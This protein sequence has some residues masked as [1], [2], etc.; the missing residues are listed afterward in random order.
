MSLSLGDVVAYLKADV[1][2]FNRGLSRARSAMSGASK[3]ITEGFNTMSGSTSG[4][5]G[6]IFKA[7][8]AVEALKGAFTLLARVAKTVVGV[9]V[10]TAKK[11]GTAA[12][13]ILMLSSRANELKVALIAVG[14]NT[15]IS[16]ERF[17]DY[18]K[19]LRATGISIM[20]ARKVLLLFTQNQ[21]DLTKVTELATV[22]QNLAVTAGMDSSE[23]MEQ[24][25]EAI[26]MQRPMLLRQFGL[27]TT[28]NDIYEK[29][30][31][32][33]TK[34]VTK[35]G[36]EGI[37]RE[38]LVRD[39]ALQ[40]ERVV[41]LNDSEKSN[42]ITRT[43]AA[44]RLTDMTARLNETKTATV[45]LKD[46]MTEEQKAAAILA[47]IM[48]EG[49]KSVGVYSESMGT[50]SKVMR[51][52]TGRVLPDMAI[53]LGDVVRPE[54]DKFITAIYDGLKKISAKM[55]PTMARMRQLW[56]MLMVDIQNYWNEYGRATFDTIIEKLRDIF[57]R[58][59]D[60]VDSENAK[61]FFE[62]LG[63]DTAQKALDIMSGMVDK[64]GIFIDYL[65]SDDFKTD[66]ENFTVA[67]RDLATVVTTIASALAWA[68]SSLADLIGK[69]REWRK[70]RKESM[71]ELSEIG[72]S[73][74]W[75]G[76]LW[77]WLKKADIGLDWFG[78]P[79]MMADGVKNFAGGLAVVGERGR[80]LVQL[81]PGSNV[82]P[83]RELGGLGATINLTVNMAGAVIPSEEVAEDFAEAVGDSIFRKLKARNTNYQ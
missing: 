23:A 29:Y 3:R 72:K 65:G 16:E 38:K 78:S 69:Y 82:I 15:G 61:K 8:V 27:V 12:Y 66:L 63:S 79:G 73:E 21:L 22:A 31:E 2:D 44:N 1:S 62:Q 28:V 83:N 59:K 33:Q 40:E 20:N 48:D 68:V 45:T 25:T 34:T 26:I 50:A 7:Q 39:I 77:D 76:G 11:V 70:E 32:T 43:T 81:P 71:D 35:M 9:F 52:I 58:L 47:Y 64:L 10:N 57:D 67:M 42:N 46:A 18:E 30:G 55:E 49:S 53:M 56:E 5:T 24:M 17:A 60:L 41:S 6:K 13:N 14:K 19:Q 36:V 75:K 37:A 4:L 80:E 51:S 74:D 54:W